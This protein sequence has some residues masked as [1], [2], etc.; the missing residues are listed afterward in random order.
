MSENDLP[1]CAT[2]AVCSKIDLYETPW[3]ERQ[4]RCPKQSYSKHLHTIY[5]AKEVKSNTNYRHMLE[6]KFKFDDTDDNDNYQRENEHMK[7]LLHK[8]GAIYNKD[9]I[10]TND[11]D[12][13]N[14]D[15]NIAPLHQSVKNKKRFDDNS[16][17]LMQNI[18]SGNTKFR[19]SGH[20]DI[21]RIGGC[22][23]AISD[24]DE[25]T[26]ADKTRLYKLCEPVH[27]LPVCR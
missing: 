24:N 25:H 2:N 13:S 12:F 4:C 1:F 15:L 26:I 20:R 8:L 10:L 17:S 27:K 14:D 9:D 11:N 5:H 18:G 19:H 16:N 3:I 21:P 7:N 6:Q 22:P 23:S